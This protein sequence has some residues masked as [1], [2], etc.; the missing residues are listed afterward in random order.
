MSDTG[1]TTWDSSIL[2][3]NYDFTLRQN[4]IKK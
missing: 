3:G 4:E 1:V 2:I